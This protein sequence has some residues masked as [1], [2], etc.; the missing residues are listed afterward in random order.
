MKHVIK[1]LGLIVALFALA[2]VTIPTVTVRAEP[3]VEDEPDT[4]PDTGL[5]TS[6][7]VPIKITLND[8]K[9]YALKSKDSFTVTFTQIDNELDYWTGNDAANLPPKEDN[10]IK[11]VTLAQASPSDFGISDDPKTLTAETEELPTDKVGIFT[12]EV[13]VKANDSAWQAATPEQVYILKLKV[14][15]KDNGEMMPDIKILKKDSKQKVDSLDF[16]FT[17][18]PQNRTVTIKHA[19]AGAYA[20][21]LPPGAKFKV[22]V[23]TA[24]TT[25]A[26][27]A[28]P[29]ATYEVDQDGTITIPD[30]RVGSTITIAELPD[31]QNPGVRLGNAGTRI[32]RDQRVNDVTVTED[33]AV[34]TNDKGVTSVAYLVTDNVSVDDDATEN[35]FTVT[36]TYRELVNTGLTLLTSPFVLLLVFT[37][38]GLSAY[39]V[40]KR[41]L[42]Y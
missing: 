19:V 36:D 9:G 33:D 40:I 6:G 4:E 39:F 41:Q 31:E 29:V 32:S 26:R 25:K 21:L 38:Q 14:T 20:P 42:N 7:K 28:N 17:L 13:T 3:I 11:D 5:T 35:A 22:K 18:T 8:T 10:P 1:W 12:Y 34:S 23:T 27:A 15:R 30:V 16:D 2:A 24:R 37:G